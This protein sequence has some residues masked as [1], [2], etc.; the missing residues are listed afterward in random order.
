MKTHEVMS[1]I[2]YNGEATLTDKD[3]PR[4]QEIINEALQMLS[5]QHDLLQKTRAI[6]EEKGFLK[7][8]GHKF[9]YKDLIY[10][11]MELPLRLISPHFKVWTSP[12]Y[13]V[14]I[15]HIA[16]IM[17]LRM[18]ENG[19]VGDDMR[20]YTLEILVEANVKGWDR[21]RAY[22]NADPLLT[23]IAYQAM[24]MIEDLPVAEQ[25]TQVLMMIFQLLLLM[26]GDLPSS[27]ISVVIDD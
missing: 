6:D 26:V 2:H 24:G 5:G 10:S 11:E 7:Q 17:A 13:I 1:F 25:Q 9:T 3:G 23:R 12:R 16:M 22:E 21:N 4:V 15:F 14:L 18:V 8:Q 19:I 27:A 20:K